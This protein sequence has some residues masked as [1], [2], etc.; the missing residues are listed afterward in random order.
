MTPLAPRIY[1]LDQLSPATGGTYSP[2][3][4][5]RA[6]SASRTTR[7]PACLPIRS[8][9]PIYASRWRCGCACAWTCARWCAGR[10]CT[11]IS[12]TTGTPGTAASTACTAFSTPAGRLK[13]R[14]R[15]S[16]FRRLR[17]TPSCATCFRSR[18]SPRAAAKAGSFAW[19]T[20]CAPP[21]NWRA[22]FLRRIAPGVEN[23]PAFFAGRLV[24]RGRMARQ[25][26]G[27]SSFHA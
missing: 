1:A 6:Q 15:I 4:P 24:L 5:C 7:K 27:S 2:T 25:D 19:R 8:P 3:P 26:G 18:P 21:A 13:T 22:W 17:K 16:R 20:S 9:W 10:S 23:A 12:S 14:A 11:T